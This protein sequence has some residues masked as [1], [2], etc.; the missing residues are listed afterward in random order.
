[1]KTDVLPGRYTSQWFQV[2]RPGRYHLFCAEYC[3]TKHSGMTG[4]IVAMEPADYQNWLAGGGG[5]E[6]TMAGMGQKLF[7]DRACVSCH[8]ADS[9]ARGPLLDGLFGKPVALTNGQVVTADEAYLRESILNPGAKVAAGF[10]P[11]MP[12]FQG[13]LNEEQLLQLIEYIKTLGAKTGGG[14]AALP[15][16]TPTPGAAGT[17]T[18]AVGKK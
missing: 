6:T 12:T 10:Q 7:A 13:L 2:T 8:R 11:I 3:G 9:Q 5:G 4:W 17:S 15:Q 14:P 16:A 18:P 1:M